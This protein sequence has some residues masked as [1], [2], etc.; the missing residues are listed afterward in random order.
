[1]KFFR[2]VLLSF[3]AFIT[4][5]AFSQMVY[6]EKDN[7][8]SL[9]Q[10][11]KTQTNSEL[12]EEKKRKQ[13][14][15]NEKQRRADL[16][17]QA[18]AHRDRL[19]EESEQLKQ[20]I[21]DNEQQLADLEAEQQRKIGDL[22][23]LFGVVRQ[24]SGELR[25]TFE[26]SMITVHY[27]QRIQMMEKL[28]ETKVLPEIS[29]LEKMWLS[30]LEELDESRKISRFDTKVVQ[31]DGM[32]KVQKV[33]RIGAYGAVSEGEFLTYSPESNLFEKLLKQ[34]SY[35]YQKSADNFDDAVAGEDFVKVMV[36]PTRGQLL[37]MLTQKPDLIDRIRQGGVIGYIILTLGFIGLLIAI[38]RYVYLTILSVQISKQV[39]DLGNPSENNALG[40]IA[41]A[42]LS[43]KDKQ[44]EQKET[45]I[46]EA[47]M[48]EVPRVEKY[49][50]LIKLLAAVSPLLG[51]LGTVTG[52]IITFQ[53][54]TLFGTSDP[55][56]MAGGIS[57]ALVT[58][59]LGLSVAIPLLFAYTFI[60]AKTKQ[61]ID[62]I[63]HQS[64]GLIAKEY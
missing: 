32:T 33:V 39:E 61:I 26:H 59:V 13:W 46:E 5:L 15:L 29:T 44:H 6:A 35:R 34:P 55:K 11:I 50:S 24:V 57:T 52:M 27:P 21:D 51:L 38:F 48:K 3:S 37:D 43:A 58:T 10:E 56:L 25:A 7:F 18:Q 22:G 64:I 36:D 16:L 63:E 49:N 40:R 53:A 28:S 20:T 23:E 30:M 60:A 17:N 62:T 54:I 9:L 45:L 47:I 8:E 41:L 2:I 1:M 4:S 19:A 42:Y 31:E 12:N 14:F